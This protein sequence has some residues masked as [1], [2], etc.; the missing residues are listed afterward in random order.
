MR[1][2]GKLFLRPRESQRKLDLAIES[3]NEKSVNF[4]TNSL[5]T[6]HEGKPEAGS[7]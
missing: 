7:R 6:P 5:K 4:F 3:R 2:G 1:G